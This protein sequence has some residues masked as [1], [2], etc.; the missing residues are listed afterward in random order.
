[1]EKKL[2]KS[3]RTKK[4]LREEL[5]ELLLTKKLEE[6][7][8]NELAKRANIVRSTF[9]THYSDIYDLYEQAE[10]DIEAEINELLIETARSRS[11]ESFLQV[12]SYIKENPK[13]C[14]L[15]FSRGTE[16]SLRLK[17]RNFVET[18][19]KPMW[20]EYNNANAENKR[21]SYIFKYHTLGCVGIIEQWA[22]NNFEESEKFII[23]TFEILENGVKNML[24]DK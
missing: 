8:V 9:Y 19:C 22:L 4:I 2:S 11:K 23:K 21:I 17:I 7:T 13:I 20:A 18:T 6:I 16:S 10:N 12:L 14:K 1:M 3:K 24:T 5:A 15:I